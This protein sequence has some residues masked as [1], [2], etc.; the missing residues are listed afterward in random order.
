MS[1]LRSL[2]A[3]LLLAAC[4]GGG[5]APVTEAPTRTEA[6]TRLE[7]RIAKKTVSNPTRL[8]VAGRAEYN[9]YLRANLPV[10]PNGERTDYIGDLTM[11]VNFAAARDEVSGRVTG[12]Q[13]GAGDR[14]RGGLAIAGG[15]I[16]RDTVVRDNYTF[17]GR[18]TGELRRGRA[19]YDVDAGLEGEFRGK[20]RSAV[21]GILFGD[22]EGP[23]GVEIFDGSF[24]A[25]R[26][27]K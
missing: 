15:D 7:S 23:K 1:Q 14:L 11:D 3:C 27:A 17:T 12:L 21:S 24:A 18:V 16:Y 13:T 6:V 8:P 4:G 25:E 22:V 2:A 19:A 9:G 20:D 26:R 5:G 10:G